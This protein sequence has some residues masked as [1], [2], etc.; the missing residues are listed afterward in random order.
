MENKKPGDNP[1]KLPDQSVQ[2]LLYYTVPYGKRTFSLFENA[3]SRQP[4]CPMNLDIFCKLIINGTFNTSIKQLR[5]MNENGYSE[6]KKRLPATTFA[7]RFAHRSKSGLIQPTG[8]VVIDIDHID[9]TVQL[10]K[11]RAKMIRDPHL[12]FSFVSP[13]GRGLK[14]VF[15]AQFTDDLTYKVAYDTVNSHVEA[16]YEIKTDH[17]GKDI[18]RLCFVSSDPEAYFNPAAEPFEIKTESQPHQQFQQPAVGQS[19][20]MSGKQQER[21]IL[22]VINGELSRVETAPRGE[23]NKAL[24][25]AA[26]KVAMY[27]HLGLFP[28]EAVK[29]LLIETYIE[30]GG[31]AKSHE[32]AS[33]TFE[34]GWN[35]GISIPRSIGGDNH[36]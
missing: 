13:S 6:N 28:K 14:C 8:F 35:Y 19:T 26:M 34:S 4:F 33:R 36:D 17:S 20:K 25:T 22:K 29:K 1:A 30:R 16:R 9:D 12:L 7:G 21:Y 3:C 27:F 10:N 32:E 24:N 15:V 18:C 2:P 5:S 23:G 11:I 31:S